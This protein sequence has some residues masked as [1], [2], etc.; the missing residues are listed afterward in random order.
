MDYALNFSQ[1]NDL[2]QRQAVA[3]RLPFRL[4][5]PESMPIQLLESWFASEVRV[6]FQPIFDV[7]ALDVPFALE[8]LSRGPRGSAFEQANSLFEVV[9]AT[10]QEVRAD[11]HCIDAALRIVAHAEPVPAIALN[12]HP[13]TLERDPAFVEFLATALARECIN[14]RRVILEILE[15]PVHW[16]VQVVAATVR[17]LRAEGVRIALDDVGV[18]LWNSRTIEDLSPDLLKVDRSVVTGSALDSNRRAV[19]RSI[20]QLADRIGA[21]VVAEGIEH[22]D[23]LQVV[24]EHGVPFGQGFLFSHPRPFDEVLERPLELRTPIKEMQSCREK[25]SSSWTTPT[26]F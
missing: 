24:I 1:I 21:Q 23:D 2:T 10:R 7:N 3:P 4:P 11:R 8:A 26:R 14:P 25:R 22:D 9:R 16:N 19:I 5:S 13:T 18:G 20:G 15:E 12:V 6:A 17:A